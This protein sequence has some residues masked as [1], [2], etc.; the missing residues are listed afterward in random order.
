VPRIPYDEFGLFYEN[1]AEHG[2]AFDAPP[3]VRR[4]S[5]EVGPQR[6]LSALVWREA[7]P[8]LVLL[9]GGGQ[10]AHTWDTV[11][12]AL[13]RPLVAID[14][15]GHGHSDAPGTSPGGQLSVEG[16]ARD[17]AAAV[18]ALAPNARAVVGMSLGGLTAIALTAV[19]PELVRS[20]VLVDI[21]PG[22]TSERTKAISAFIN[23]PV[24]FPSF[25]DLLARTIEHNPTRSVSSLRRGI[26][27]NAMQLDDDSW[28][29]RYRRFDQPIARDDAG[30]QRLVEQRTP[31]D[32]G[33]LWDVLGAVAVPVMLMRG[34]TAQSAVD[35]SEEIELRR[36]LPAVRVEQ[37][38]GA[39]HSI[40]GDQP[41]VLAGLLESFVST[42]G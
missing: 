22:V 27:H 34:T 31:T 7:E 35:D 3:V 33:A 19:A 29:W 16:N 20:L 37:V 6:H 21:T 36:R 30:E 32:P 1:A 41:V 11:A 10:N 12:L 39:G 4:A 15:P 13:G 2:L 26:L 38:A 5:V 23:G 42:A 18:R 28:V 24:S 14:L 17:V 8:E 9:H 25:D 40:Q